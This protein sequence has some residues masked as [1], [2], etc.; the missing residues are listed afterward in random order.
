MRGADFRDRRRDTAPAG[1][2]SRIGSI[3]L[4]RTSAGPGFDLPPGEASARHPVNSTTARQAGGLNFL[5]AALAA[6]KK[7]QKHFGASMLDLHRV[8]RT[9][10][11][12]RI[13][14]IRISIS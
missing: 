8:H 9:P 2:L 12:A 10:V 7:I 4:Y 5:A 11:W 13:N 3:R 14:Y 1:A 6:G